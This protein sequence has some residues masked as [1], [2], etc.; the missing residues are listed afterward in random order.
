MAGKGP[1]LVGFAFRVIRR[2]GV[3]IA[4]IAIGGGALAVVLARH[5]ERLYEASTELLVRFGWEYVARPVGGEGW[6]PARMAELVNAEVRILNSRS[7]RAGALGA[8]GVDTVYPALREDAG[9]GHG[10][11][12][13]L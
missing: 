6:Q 11:L 12:E 2:Y 8:L 13:R 1:D 10:L 5:Q 7:V 3:L 9:E 4:I